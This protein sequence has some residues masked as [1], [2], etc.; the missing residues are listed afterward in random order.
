MCWF[1]PPEEHKRYVKLLCRN[2]VNAIKNQERD[3]DLLSF[4][5]KDVHTLIDHL[6]TGECDEKTNGDD[7]NDNHNDND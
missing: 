5:I 7:Y 4:G 3:G 1:E 6:Y 2:I